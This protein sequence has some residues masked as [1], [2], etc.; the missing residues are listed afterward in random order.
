MIKKHYDSSQLARTVSQKFRTEDNIYDYI[1]N[2]PLKFVHGY[3][4]ATP[5]TGL[6]SGQ[7]GIC[8]EA[9]IAA[10]KIGPGG[11]G[12][13]DGRGHNGNNRQLTA[14]I[15]VW[16]IISTDSKKVYENSFSITNFTVVVYFPNVILPSTRRVSNGKME[17]K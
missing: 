15:T 4:R 16:T 1:V 8:F 3:A 7:V 12:H 9:F 6:E 13:G 5:P 14:R 10:A 17:R 2:S 11:I